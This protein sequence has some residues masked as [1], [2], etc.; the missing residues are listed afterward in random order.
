MTVCSYRSHTVPFKNEFI[1]DSISYSYNAALSK[2]SFCF[3][4]VLK[5]ILCHSYHFFRC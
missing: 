2:N 4:L 3:R 1:S 5:L